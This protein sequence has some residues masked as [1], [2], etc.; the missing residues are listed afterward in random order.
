MT[1]I[2]NMFVVVAANARSDSLEYASAVRR[3]F[4]LGRPVRA[5]QGRNPN[6]QNPNLSHQNNE[7]YIDLGLFTCVQ[8][9]GVILDG[10]KRVLLFRFVRADGLDLKTV[11][12]VN[13]DPSADEYR[14]VARQ[15]QA[16]D[17]VSKG[18]KSSLEYGQTSVSE[19]QA[20]GT[21]EARLNLKRAR[22]VSAE[23]P[24]ENNK[25]SRN[26]RSEYSALAT[27]SD[28]YHAIP[29][30][31]PA[32]SSD[33]RTEDVNTTTDRVVL[34]P[35]YQHNSPSERRAS[36]KGN[37]K[38]TEIE[39]DS[40]SENGHRG[41]V[42]SGSVRYFK[43]NSLRRKLSPSVQNRK[44]SNEATPTRGLAKKKGSSFNNSDLPLRGQHEAPVQRRTSMQSLSNTASSAALD[45]SN[46]KAMGRG[47]LSRVR[48]ILN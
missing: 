41:D 46:L 31:Y 5:I 12:T 20:R 2:S 27:S 42:K 13:L 48:L 26:A 40:R 24:V 44:S 21:G 18:G 14:E 22:T 39:T 43:F 17:A 25:R 9:Q 16:K 23:A 11:K 8:Y 4:E 28:Q 1:D 33:S 29:Y 19:K 15:S 30:A 36:N 3:A 6:Y 37:A 10:V 35:S 38:E 32:E 7:G 47:G 45:R 34:G